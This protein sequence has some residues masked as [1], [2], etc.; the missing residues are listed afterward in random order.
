MNDD[1]L[2]M[3]Y[4]LFALL[5]VLDKRVHFKHRIWRLSLGSRDLR[6]R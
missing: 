6:I 2:T 5:A 3:T 1:N 4:V